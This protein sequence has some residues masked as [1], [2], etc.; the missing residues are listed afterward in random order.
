MGGI[1]GGRIDMLLLDRLDFLRDFV[2]LLCQAVLHEMR[3]RDCELL[4]LRGLLQ[5]LVGLLL[6]EPHVLVLLVAHR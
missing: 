3:V 4:H 6:D 1:D 5:V 2:R